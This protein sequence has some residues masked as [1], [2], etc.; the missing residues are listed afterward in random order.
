MASFLGSV[1]FGVMLFAVGYI[2]GHV[3]PIGKL[4]SW[5]GLGK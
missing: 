5:I 4:T 2:V 3:I 1:W